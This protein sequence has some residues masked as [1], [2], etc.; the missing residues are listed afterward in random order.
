LTVDRLRAGCLLLAC[1]HLVISGWLPRD[2]TPSDLVGLE[3]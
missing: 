2:Q 3:I 1:D